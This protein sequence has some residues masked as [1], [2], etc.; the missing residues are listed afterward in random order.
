MTKTNDTIT[1]KQ[2]KTVIY[3]LCDSGY[4]ELNFDRKIESNAKY[5]TRIL[6]ISHE[7][8]NLVFKEETSPDDNLNDY[9]MDSIIKINN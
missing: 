9:K 6:V 7:H 1:V 8:K 5:I 4:Y 2:L 3:L